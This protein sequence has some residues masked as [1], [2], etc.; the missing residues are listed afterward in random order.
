MK[1]EGIKKA[2]EFLLLLMVVSFF[3]IKTNKLNHL[4]KGWNL[5]RFLYRTLSNSTINTEFEAIN[6]INQ[7]FNDLEKGDISEA[8]YKSKLVENFLNYYMSEQS[9]VSGWSR[10]DVLPVLNGMLLSEVYYA[11]GDFKKAFQCFLDIEKKK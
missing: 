6:C 11:L 10:A 5:D 2:V 4:L 9:T 3:L 8:Y 1:D 7:A